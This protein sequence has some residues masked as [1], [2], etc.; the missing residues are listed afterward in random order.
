M[1]NG[2]DAYSTAQQQIAERENDGKVK[3]EWSTI[4]QF[5]SE[6]SDEDLEDYKRQAMNNNPDIAE[7]LQN[8]DPRKSKLLM[9]EI[10]KV[11]GVGA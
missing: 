10:A 3:R 4:T 2:T 5:I 11:A 7:F 1:S 9:G 8:K 6:Q